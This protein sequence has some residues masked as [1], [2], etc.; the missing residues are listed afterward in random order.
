MLPDSCW[1]LAWGYPSNVKIEEIFYPE[2]S[3]DIGLIQG[4]ISQDIE[5]FI[6]T[7]MRTSLQMLL[8][9]IQINIFLSTIPFNLC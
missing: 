2:T 4:V 1:L 8:M 9:Q 7:A 6:T 3:V 5:L